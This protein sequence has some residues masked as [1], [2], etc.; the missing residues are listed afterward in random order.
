MS[1][2]QF[3]LGAPHTGKSSKILN[4]IKEKCADNPTGNP[5][6]ILTPEQMTF[7][8]EYQL[9]LAGRGNSL[10]RANALSFNRLAHRVMQEVGGLARYHLDE[11]GKAML[12]QKIMTNG[13]NDLGIYQ[14]YAKKP[15]FIKKMDEL[16]AE[17]K[18]YQLDTDTLRNQLRGEE[19]LRPQTQQK[20]STLMAIYDAFNESVLTQYLTTEDYF[21][22]LQEQ[23]PQSQLLRTAEIYIDGYHTFNP[24]EQ[25]IIQ[26]LAGHAKK[27][28]IALT[29][30][31]DATTPLYETTRKTYQNLTEKFTEIG[32]DVTVQNRQGV[33][34]TT[35]SGHL[36][37]AFMQSQAPYSGRTGMS[38]FSAPSKRE[39]IEE[40]ARRIYE[41]VQTG[42]A[43]YNNVAIYAANPADDARLY[44]ALL[45]KHG[46]PYF[47]DVKEPMLTHPVIQL[48]H[49]VFDVFTSHWHQRAIFR[50]LRSGLFVNTEQFAQGSDY[51]AA[52]ARHLEDIDV[53]EN[54]V[55]A[56][57]IRKSDWTSGEEWVYSR[58]HGATQT[59]EDLA[60]QASLNAVK[61]RVVVPLM[62]LEARLGESKTVRDFAT[63]VF[64]CLESLEIPQKKLPLLEATASGRHQVK[65]KKQHEQVWPKVLSLFEQLIE[66]GGSEELGLPDFI[67]IMK[68]G[69]E[70]LSYATIPASLDAVQIGSVKRSRYQLA[71]NFNA[72][73]DYG[74][75]HAFIIGLNDGVLPSTPAES[76]LL[77][78]RDRE[79]LLKLEIQLAPSL[80]QSQ[81]D[82]IF[83]LYT[84]ASAAKE[85]LTVSYETADDRFPSYVFS[86]LERLFPDVAVDKVTSDDVYER[87]T[88]SQALFGQTLLQVKQNP[89]E[90]GYV[91]PILQYYHTYEPLR[92]DLLKKSL[93]YDNATEKLGAADAKAIY[94]EEMEASVSRIERFNNCEFAHF[95]SHGL[96]LRERKLAEMT[97]PD[98]GTLYHEVLK[99]ISLLL[100]KDRKSFADLTDGDCHRLVEIGIRAV[101]EQFAFSIL[102][103]NERM[104]TLRSKLA[105]VV[106]QTLLTLSR[107]A[108]RSGFKERAFELPFGRRPSDVIK[109]DQRQV[110][111]VKFSL[112]GI[113]DRIDVA[114]GEGKSYLRVVD[115]KSGKNAL[116]LDAVYYGLSLQLLTYLDVAIRGASQIS[117]VGGAL[118]FHVHRPYV[119]HN[120]E[121]LTSETL[122]DELVA[123]QAGEQRMSG[124][125]PENHEVA[126]LSDAE[127]DVTRGAS[128]IVPVTLKKDGAFAARGN[129][130]LAAGD[131]DVLREFSNR[132]IEQSVSRM[133]EGSLAI[134][135]MRHKGQSACDWCAYKAVC[136]FDSAHNKYRSLPKMTADEALA[137]IKELMEQP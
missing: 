117:D 72:P 67:S 135:P 61:Q 40:A 24:L 102:S 11:V 99:Y 115:Y 43:N 123:M 12:L 129:R 114:Q 134:N 110:G 73:S 51:E 94:G 57:T 75:K 83:S 68:A 112:R 47:L 60:I 32:L 79:E 41:L 59:D 44:E 90:Q 22:L 2:V 86:Q 4:E 74:I 13:T 56:R 37:D 28:T 58:F 104:R 108:G 71:T 107:Q 35:A 55:L 29:L 62:T 9:L 46:I 122:M 89:E 105:G 65:E 25:A 17:F 64:E 136:K 1:H 7:H 27:L 19:T 101:A 121:I 133:T 95:M 16:F 100:K 80:V 109:T 120:A 54:Y 82:D 31:V 50:V 63:A 78:E 20:L 137:K 6:F 103:R 111:D 132:K 52:V 36:T 130:V 21:T 34:R 116:E 53:L 5:I 124:Y 81:Q 126:R 128:D 85:T 106:Y 98:I 48:L 66:V 42:Q 76:S 88:T 15:G 23:I 119:T 87:L 84:V 93:G 8:T 45:T 18:N 26:K 77:T 14:N 113:I 3:I 30:D 39:E 70:Q 10:I 69:L 97:L 92:Y 96:R 91:E 131:F 49:T 127:L 118:Y 38:F 125:L 33:S